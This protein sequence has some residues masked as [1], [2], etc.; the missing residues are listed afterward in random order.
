MGW[1]RGCLIVGASGVDD[2]D[3]G[4]RL[5]QEA[6]PRPPAPFPGPLPADGNCG[7]EQA[8]TDPCLGPVS[9]L[10]RR[11][12]VGDRIGLLAVRSLPV[13]PVTQ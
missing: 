8:K 10:A 12:R 5:P 6:T 7:P 1:W 9:P 11:Q 4:R 3:V 13:H 2:F